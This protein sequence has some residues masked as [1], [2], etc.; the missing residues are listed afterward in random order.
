M[1]WPPD[2]DAPIDPQ[3]RAFLDDIAENPDDAGVRLIFADWLEE[4]GDPRAELVRF[5]VE[6]LRNPRCKETKRLAN[7]WMATHGVAWLGEQIDSW[8]T[9]RP[10]ENLVEVRA[11]GDTRFLHDPKRKG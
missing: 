3:V 6:H 8:A 1:N 4:H 7:E 11:F 10:A 2:V 5:Q 9:F